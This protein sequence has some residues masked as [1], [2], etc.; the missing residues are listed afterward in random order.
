MEEKNSMNIVLAVV[1]CLIL[2]GVFIFISLNNKKENMS[3]IIVAKM[4][5]TVSMNYTGRLEDGA[6]FDSN[7]DPRFGHVAPFEFTLGAGQVIA[8]WDK[9][10][11]GMKVGE[12]KTLI[13]PPEDAYG[14]NGQGPIPPNATLIFDVELLEIKK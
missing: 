9:G 1:I 11:A 8:G 4:G 12:K 7:V 10:I 13:I 14:E 2:A 3:E 5:D 6:V